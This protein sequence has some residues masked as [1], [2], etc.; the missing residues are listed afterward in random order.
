M[1]GL[2]TTKKQEA[3]RGVRLPCV[4][5][6]N[7]S[8]VAPIAAPWRL[9]LPESEFQLV[10]PWSGPLC[11][12]ENAAALSDK[13]STVVPGKNIYLRMAVAEFTSFCSLFIVGVPPGD[14]KLNC[15]FHFSLVECC[16]WGMEE[17]ISRAGKRSLT[18]AR[19]SWLLGWIP[20]A[21]PLPPSMGKHLHKLLLR[22][23]QYRG[24]IGHRDWVG[25][26]RGADCWV[27]ASS[28]QDMD[29][30][31]YFCCW[32]HLL[33]HRPINLQWR[34]SHPPPQQWLINLPRLK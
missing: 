8:R 1:T 17:D 28:S 22:E 19:I 21:Q 20:T 9:K 16:Q 34:R 6:G 14:L 27:T 30:N 24:C 23:L 33:E 13:C 26:G 31:H 29:S 15:C 25:Q 5:I 10:K 3:V 7:A 4:L 32:S 12:W 18:A 2:N 11:L